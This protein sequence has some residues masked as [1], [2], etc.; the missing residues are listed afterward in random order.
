MFPDP[1]APESP[2]KLE[3]LLGKTWTE[4]NEWIFRS[5]SGERRQDGVAYRG[6]VY[7]LGTTKIAPKPERARA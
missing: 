4:V 2:T 1:E 6:P 3:I 7:L 5:W